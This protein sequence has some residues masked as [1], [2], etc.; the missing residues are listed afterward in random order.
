MHLSRKT[1]KRQHRVRKTK[2]ATK[3]KHNKNHKK[4]HKRNKNK[5]TS[6]RKII[7]RKQTQR[8]NSDTKASKKNTRK[9][10]FRG[11]GNVIKRFF[12]KDKNLIS[13]NSIQVHTFVIRI[14]AY[15]THKINTGS[16]QHNVMYFIDKVNKLYD[17]TLD[18]NEVHK[19]IQEYIVKQNEQEEVYKNTEQYIENNSEIDN[20]K[21]NNLDKFFAINNIDLHKNIVIPDTFVYKGST[22]MGEVQLEKNVIPSFNCQENFT[23]SLTYCAFVS[24][25][26]LTIKEE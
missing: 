7:K 22:G 1:R 6:K 8:Q 26:H 10:I 5:N 21:R 17:N 13:T 12:K 3:R 2:S 20:D 14:L 9:M 15:I 16:K 11:G 19:H 23:S 18:R 25:S 24:D 4:N